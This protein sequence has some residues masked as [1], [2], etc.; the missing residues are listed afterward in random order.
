MIMGGLPPGYPLGIPGAPRALRCR[1]GLAAAGALAAA[2]SS[3]LPSYQAANYQA[4]AK[5]PAA[6]QPGP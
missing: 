6:D 2:A 4:V 1:A 5:L 3:K